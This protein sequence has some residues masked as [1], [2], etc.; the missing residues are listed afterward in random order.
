VSETPAGW[1]DDPLGIGEK[2]YWDG[3]SWTQ[4]ITLSRAVQSVPRASAAAKTRSWWQIALV[5]L[6]SWMLLS[7]C[8][9]LGVVLDDESFSWGDFDLLG[10]ETAGEATWDEDDEDPAGDGPSADSGHA[11][12][13]SDAQSSD[14][15]Q[16]GSVSQL[17]GT[18]VGT[19]V[20]EDG[21]VWPP[22]P[23]ELYSDGTGRWEV[24]YP[25]EITWQLSSYHDMPAIVMS[26]PTKGSVYLYEC[27][28][29]NLHLK[30]VYQNGFD[31]AIDY[32]LA[33]Q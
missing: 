23:L 31:M 19:E 33:R 25:S 12:D 24:N 13:D 22:G 18:W 11:Q 30:L 26:Y 17:Y 15:A 3:R 16:L 1:Y 5:V 14:G 10:G 20:T 7:L 6:G 9:S 28:G 2:R 32:F 4:Q 8:V 29:S 21:G 27:D